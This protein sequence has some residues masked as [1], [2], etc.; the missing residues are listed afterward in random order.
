MEMTFKEEFHDFGRVKKGNK[1]EHTFKF[2]NTGK[3]A[4]TLELVS[5]CE[6]SEIIYDEGATY[7]AGEKGEIRVIFHSDE[8]E[9][10]KVEKTLD[11]LL[12]N[13]NPRTGYQYVLELRY[14]AIIY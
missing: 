14:G 2:T 4:I 3:E 1:V 12:E 11:I 7:K 6:C 5:G 10:G 8:E 9:R 13:I